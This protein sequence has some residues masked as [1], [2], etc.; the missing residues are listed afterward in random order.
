MGYWRRVRSLALRDK[1]RSCEIRKTLNVEQLLRT[2]ISA[3]L[4]MWPECPRKNWRGKS[5]W[6]HSRENGPKVNQ[7]PGDVITFQTLL[8]PVLVWS[9]QKGCGP[10]PRGKAGMSMNEWMFRVQFCSICYGYYLRKL[11]PEKFK[12]KTTIIITILFR[13]LH[14]LLVGCFV[15]FQRFDLADRKDILRL[16]LIISEYRNGHKAMF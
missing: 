9:Q 1:A 13:L 14:V 8:S 7:R 15:V 2:E 6:L 4:A 10:S 16:Q 12:V 5:C 11:L 3:M